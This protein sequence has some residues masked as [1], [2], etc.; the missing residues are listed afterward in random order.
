MTAITI[1]TGKKADLPRVLELVRELAAFERASHEVTNTVH[2]MEQDGFG[3]HPVFGFFVAERDNDIV[4]L[5][6]FYYRYSTWKGKRIYLE[7][8][9]VT[10][11]ERGK[12]IGKLLFERTMRKTL[13]DG[14]SGMTWQALDWN[15]PALTFYRK[16]N[17]KLDGEWITC[18]LEAEQIRQFIDGAQK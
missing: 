17:S 18:T 13:E 4:G 9:I 16:Y 3:P 7:D 6:L 11:R 8:I 1:R 14:C 10:E 15:E 5:S 2:D 12:G